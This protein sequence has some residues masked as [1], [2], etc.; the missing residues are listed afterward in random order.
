M[1]AHDHFDH[2]QHVFQGWKEDLLAQDAMPL[3]LVGQHA[4]LPGQGHGDLFVWLAD[5]PG[6]NLSLLRAI[7]EEALIALELQSEANPEEG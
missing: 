4:P 1:E 2:I 7:L 5:Q 6:A 3:F